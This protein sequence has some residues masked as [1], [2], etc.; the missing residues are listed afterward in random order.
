MLSW[1]HAG[2]SVLAAF[3]ASL[4]EFV[5]ALTVVLAVGVVRGWRPAL[6]GTGLALVVLLVLIVILGGSLAFIVLVWVAVCGVALPTL[7]PPSSWHGPILFVG[8]ALILV[9]NALRGARRR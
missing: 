8:L 7:V 4:V 2:P 9:E 6:A 5:E 3:L 1:A